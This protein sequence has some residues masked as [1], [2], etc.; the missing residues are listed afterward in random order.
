MT[1]LNSRP[2]MTTPVHIRLE[3]VTWTGSMAITPEP[4]KVL[5]SYQTIRDHES[6]RLHRE[7]RYTPVSVFPV[8]C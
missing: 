7:K 3:G 6:W 8:L 2:E 1:H 4:K 5:N